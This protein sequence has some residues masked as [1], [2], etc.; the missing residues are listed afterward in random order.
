M[1]HDRH[2]DDP[3]LRVRIDQG[4]LVVAPGVFD[5]FSAMLAQRSNFAAVYLGGYAVSGS[6]YGLPDAGLVGL[7]EMLDAIAVV[8]RVCD[9]PMIADADTGYGGL[10]NVQH[11][12]REYEALGVSAIQLEDQEMPKRCGHTQGKRVIGANEMAAKIDVAIETRRSDD[13]LII[14]RTDSRAALGLDEAI[15]RGR[16]YRSAGADVVFV[17]APESFDEIARVAAEIEGPLL[18]N[19]VPRGFRT[20]ETDV[21]ELRRLGFNLAIYPGL[22]AVAGMGAMDA[23]LERLLARGDVDPDGGP[24][25]SPHELV[26]FPDVWAD[27]A[28]WQQRYGDLE[29]AE[30]P[31]TGS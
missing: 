19:V 11:T 4:D 12:V 16:L 26:G 7:R 24:P 30:A 1:P 6:R 20:P 14:A 27:E 8:R 13:C 25:F 18:I 22:L 17:E 3:G 23:A 10:L 9:K 15:R 2:S 28:R 29:D 21:A 31:A 5:G